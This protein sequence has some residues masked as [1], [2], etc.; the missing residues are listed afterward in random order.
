MAYGG[1]LLENG[2]FF[3]DRTRNLFLRAGMYKERE[4]A[5][6]LKKLTQQ[7]IFKS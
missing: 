6:V 7:R 3:S 4:G 1:S 5:E 2:S